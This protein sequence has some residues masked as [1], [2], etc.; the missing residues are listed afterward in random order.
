MGQTYE[1]KG[2]GAYGESGPAN[3]QM[4]SWRLN[5]SGRNKRS[6]WTITSKPFKGAHFATFP[7]DLVEPM[8]LSSTSHKGEY[9]SVVL[10]PFCGSGTV[11]MV[12]RQ[13][14]RKFIGLD[15]SLEYLRDIALPRSENNQ[16]KEAIETLP[17]FGGEKQ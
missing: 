9:P 2:R 1:G 4:E 12:A 11:G 13:Y 7:P 10:D 16:T 3:G 17:L 15:L 14:G 5:P 6:V 8:L